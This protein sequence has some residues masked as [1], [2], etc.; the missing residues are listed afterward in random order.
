[1][2]KQWFVL[3]GV[4]DIVRV[5]VCDD[6]SNY[7]SDRFSVTVDGKLVGHVNGLN[8]FTQKKVVFKMPTSGTMAFVLFY[9]AIRP[10]FT[11]VVDSRNIKTGC[12]YRS[13]NQLSKKF[14]HTIGAVLTGCF[15]S[16]STASVSI[17]LYNQIREEETTWV[18]PHIPEHVSAYH[19]NSAAMSPLQNPETEAVDAPN[20]EV[21]P[22]PFF[23][24]FKEISLMVVFFSQILSTRHDTT[25]HDPPF[26]LLPFLFV[27]LK[28][29]NFTCYGLSRLIIC[30]LLLLK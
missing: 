12:S 24:F 7:F 17:S 15:S 18:D 29:L 4:N 10:R 27:Y 28:T 8:A 1:M 22:Y 14:G 16:W 19:S 20:M 3:D 30:F 25:L 23:S 6:K 13:A 2:K 11:L 5:C 26:T 9:W 21:I